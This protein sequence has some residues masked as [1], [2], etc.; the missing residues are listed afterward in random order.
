[1]KSLENKIPPPV[2]MLI[3]AATMW[4]AAK[5]QSPVSIESH[6]RIGLM[7]TLGVVALTFSIGGVTAFRAAKTTINPAQIDRASRVVTGGIYRF[8]RNP[9]YVGLTALLAGWAVFL[10]VPLTAIGPIAFALFMHRFQILPEERV[11]A[12]KFG[13]EYLDYKQRVRRWI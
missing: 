3:V 9:M 1:M 12:A 6:L 2:L 11:M 5:I 4:G 7:L 8:S 10:A 13:R